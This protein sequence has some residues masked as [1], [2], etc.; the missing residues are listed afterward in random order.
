[1]KYEISLK[2]SKKLVQQ[3]VIAYWKKS[4]GLP[5]PIVCILMTIFG[6]YLLFKGSH[7][8]LAVAILTS[9]AIGFAIIL[10]A[11]IVHYKNSMNKLNKMGIPEAILIAEDDCFTITTSKS[12]SINQWSVVKEAWCYDDF[13]LLLFSK[14]HFITIPLDNMPSEAKLYIIKQIKDAGG[15]IVS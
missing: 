8:L 14:A 5:L 7:S 3:A 1:M 2:Y 15:R 11:Y 9:T 12:S 10:S 13:W 6:G 4:I